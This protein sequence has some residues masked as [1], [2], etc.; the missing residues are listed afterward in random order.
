[1]QYYCS[2][3]LLE[4]N[5]LFDSNHVLISTDNNDDSILDNNDLGILKIQLNWDH[6]Q[7]A[8]YIKESLKEGIHNIYNILLNGPFDTYTNQGVDYDSVD[9]KKFLKKI[10]KDWTKQKHNF[11]DIIIKNNVKQI[12]INSNDNKNIKLLIPLVEL[13]FKEY[14]LYTHARVYEDD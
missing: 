13:A 7:I 6:E 3:L 2:Y 5:F 10:I 11:N 1:M 14:M 4:D 12:N 8:E 9:M